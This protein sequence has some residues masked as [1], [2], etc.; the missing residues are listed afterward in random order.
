MQ[1]CPA[2][3]PIYPQTYP[4]S[5]GAAHGLLWTSADLIGRPTQAS[6][7]QSLWLTPVSILRHG[8]DAE[9]YVAANLQQR[10]ERRPRSRSRQWRATIPIAAPTRSRAGPCAGPPGEIGTCAGNK[11]SVHE[12]QPKRWAISECGK[13]GSRSP[14]SL[15]PGCGWKAEIPTRPTMSRNFFDNSA[16]LSARPPRARHRVAIDQGRSCW[17]PSDQEHIPHQEMS[18]S[19]NPRGSVTSRH[20]PEATARPS[21]GPRVQHADDPCRARCRRRRP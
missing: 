9:S 8:S 12:S 5:G 7:P 21:A 14:P 16:R 18:P 13:R 6:A 11:R 2:L 15:K 3:R 19:S 17:M 4:R 1:S 20:S 10:T